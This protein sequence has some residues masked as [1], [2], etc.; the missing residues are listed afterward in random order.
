MWQRNI[1]S[2]SLKKRTKVSVAAETKTAAGKGG[3]ALCPDSCFTHIHTSA[4]IG[5]SHSVL[6]VFKAAN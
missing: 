3:A 4:G 2:Q 5:L 1:C 6:S